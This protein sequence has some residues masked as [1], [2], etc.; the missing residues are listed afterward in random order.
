M[1]INSIA[2]V[3]AALFSTNV[4][5]AQFNCGVFLDDNDNPSA[6]GKFDTT[7]GTRTTMQAGTF[8]GFVQVNEKADAG[9]GIATDEPMILIGNVA[10]DKTVSAAAYPTNADLMIAL[11]KTSNGKQALTACAAAG[12]ELFRPAGI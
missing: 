12:K 10:T 9:A 7:S 8:V 4:F 3:A 2:F 6:T 1:K 11:L 5:A